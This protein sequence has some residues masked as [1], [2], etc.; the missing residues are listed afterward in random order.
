[1][2]VPREAPDRTDAPSRTA[3]DQPDP[4]VRLLRDADVCHQPRAALGRVPERDPPLDHGSR[5]LAEAHSAALGTQQP[6]SEPLVL[7]PRDPRARSD[8]HATR[9]VAHHLPAGD[10]LRRTTPRGVVVGTDYHAPAR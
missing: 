3:A 10:S 9:R 1:M 7:P 2:I 5:A 6:D 8:D 4:R